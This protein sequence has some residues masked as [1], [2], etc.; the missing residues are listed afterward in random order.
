MKRSVLNPYRR[1]GDFEG[2]V[3][4]MDVLIQNNPLRIKVIVVRVRNMGHLGPRAKFQL[5]S[6]S[7]GDGLLISHPDRLP[8]IQLTDRNLGWLIVRVLRPCITQRHIRMSTHF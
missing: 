1:P 6:L 2:L 5:R 3:L 7:F 4:Y 8:E